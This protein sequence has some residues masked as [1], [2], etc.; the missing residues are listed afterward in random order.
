MFLSS[1]QVPQLEWRSGKE[2]KSKEKKGK[3]GNGDELT[4]GIVVLLH[5]CSLEM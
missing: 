3:R 5:L 1:P 2:M 4:L